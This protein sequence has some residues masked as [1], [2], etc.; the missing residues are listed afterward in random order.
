MGTATKSPAT[1]G[2]KH[3]AIPAPN[4][5][6]A[7]FTI[8]GTAPLVGNKFSA[9]A[10]AEM[11]A[12]QEEGST[13]K[14]GKKRDPKNFE[15]CYSETIHRAPA[16]WCGIP[17]PAFRN[18]MISACKVCGYAMTRAKLSVFV[19]ADGNDKDDGT[20][21]VKIT[22]GKPEYS[23]HFVRNESGV[24]DIRPRPMWPAGW[25]AVV[26]VQFDAD[27][28][29]LDDVANLL[30][31]AGIQVGIGAGRPDSRESNGMGWGLFTIKGGK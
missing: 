13:A 24:C 16:G 3:L 21:L 27:Q 4:F 18:S 11:K 7:S 26:R 10:M 9:R 8:Q 25:E 20:P 29:T 22:K 31:R 28:F 2:E 19:L 30:A 6:V 15:Q 5:R 14:K 17:A 23:E 1:Y 12:K